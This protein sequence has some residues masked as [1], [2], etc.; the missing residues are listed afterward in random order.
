M[1]YETSFNRNEKQLHFNNIRGII[2]E[3]NVNGDWCSITLN[4]GHENP[5]F[6]NLSMKKSEFE[7]INDKYSVGDKVCVR[8]YLTSRAKNDRWYTTANILQIDAD[9]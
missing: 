1:Q 6:V 4:V 2:H 5:R 8:F 9:N 7:K 3:K